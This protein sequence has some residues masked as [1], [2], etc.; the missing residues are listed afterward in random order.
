MADVELNKGVQIL[1]ERMSSN[2]DEFIPDLRN[3]YPPKWR[4]ILLSVEMRT[5]GGKDYKDQLPFLTDKEIKALWEKMQG[6]QGDLFTKRVMNT[7]LKD[8]V[9]DNFLYANTANMTASVSGL[10]GT[11][12]IHPPTTLVPPLTTAEL[13]SLSRQVAGGR[14]KGK[15]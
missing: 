3:G 4:D 2:P 13:S 1:L 9:E 7:L 15:F 6:L 11:V 10:S 14:L 8:S 5:N 12:S